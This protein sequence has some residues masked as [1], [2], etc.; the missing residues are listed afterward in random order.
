MQIIPNAEQLKVIREWAEPILLPF[1]VWAWK[2]GIRKLRENLNGIITANVN[3]T[4]DEILTYVK[5]HMQQH[6]DCDREQFDALRSALNL[7][8]HKPVLT[9][10]DLEK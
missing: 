1:L 9:D 10:L 7:P 8:P 6:L 5:I 4:R 2:T 3:R